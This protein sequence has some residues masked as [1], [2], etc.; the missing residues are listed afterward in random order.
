M[1]GLRAPGLGPIVGHTTD[2]SCRLWIRADDPG[3]EG[4]QLDSER[5]T[6]GVIAVVGKNDV[7]IPKSDVRVHYFRLRR[8][9]DRTGTFALGVDIGIKE[10]SASEKLEPDTIYSVRLGTL[11]IDD[12]FRNDQNVKNEM[13]ADLLPDPSAWY[14]PLIDR[15]STRLNSSHIQK[16]RMPSSA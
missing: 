2:R 3:D 15:K 12:P 16:S 7:K 13:L 9:F 14:D 8:E 6:L 5:R 11:T 10:K 1:S 4:A